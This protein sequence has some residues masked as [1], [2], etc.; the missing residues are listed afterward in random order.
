MFDN[1][2]KILLEKYKSI[3]NPLLVE[4]V[5]NRIQKY[6]IT[7]PYL[8][9]FIF[10]YENI[11]PWVKIKSIEDLN[12][13]IRDVLI[14][15]LIDRTDRK[16][17][18]SNAK[19]LYCT[20]INWKRQVEILQNAASGGNQDAVA[21]LQ[22]FKNNPELAKEMLSKQVNDSKENSFN[23][24]NNYILNDNDVYK[25]NPAF[26]FLILS[27]I[28]SSTDNT[29]TAEIAP[30]NQRVVADI[31]DNIANNPTMQNSI[32]QLYV[33]GVIKDAQDTE[34]KKIRSGNGEWIKIPSK[35]ND[36]DNYDENLKSLMSLAAGTN[37]CIAGFNMANNY[38]SE[39]DFYIYFLEQEGKKQ[40]VAAIRM[41]E[42][43][44]AEIR[45]TLANQEMDDKYIDNVLDLV[46]A[47][48]LKGGLDF[49]EKLQ[50]Q[51][52]DAA[53]RKAMAKLINGEPL[54][55]DEQ[56]WAGILDEFN[57]GDHLDKIAIIARDR[58]PLTDKVKQIIFD[59]IDTCLHQDTV[60][61]IGG[62]FWPK[63]LKI[64][65]DT[66]EQGIVVIET[67]F[68]KLFSYMSNDM[69]KHVNS[70][71]R[72]MLLLKMIYDRHIIGPMIA[73][74]FGQEVYEKFASIFEKL[75]NHDKPSEVIEGI[76]KIFDIDFYNPS[77]AELLYYLAYDVIQHELELKGYY[78]TPICLDRFFEQNP[79]VDG[80]MIDK[81]LYALANTN[82]PKQLIERFRQDEMLVSSSLIEQSSVSERLA[83][84]EFEKLPENSL[85]R[86][87]DLALFS[88]ETDQTDFYIKLPFEELVKFYSKEQLINIAIKLLNLANPS[89]GYYKKFALNCLKLPQ[90]IK[91]KNLI[92]ELFFR[93]LLYSDIEYY[94][95]LNREVEIFLKT[96]IP[97]VE[98][99]K[100]FLKTK[101]LRV[102]F[103]NIIDRAINSK[104]DNIRQESKIADLFKSFL[105]R[106]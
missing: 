14:K 21:S 42:D 75:T 106:S 87:V 61:D 38:L 98:E 82:I 10:R 51:K 58:L 67:F 95:Y 100:N 9:N 39:G 50:E 59:V 27:S 44:I 4:S 80:A 37:W 25:Q 81:I 68:D 57:R 89:V 71:T 22:V 2:S 77:Y 72:G 32:H 73:G 105:L 104:E 85:V 8:I 55:K 76:A 13:F 23:I 48:N 78:N 84:I 60:G 40:G 88:V 54:D 41:R 35:K 28:F 49:V 47:E 46:K 94:G 36:P 18:S 91:D 34:L 24:W 52:I 43:R 6:R 20:K 29:S 83:W 92:Y 74:T 97:N 12:V 19:T 86:L 30:L 79:N 101:N 70:Q 96:K 90:P 17:M 65:N 3:Y 45:G 53:R 64:Y 99:F 93:I 26:Q 69:D 16:Q 103:L 15:M 62:Y 66:P 7:D 56:E 31:F 11:V 33:D 5:K 63:L 102:E 1:D